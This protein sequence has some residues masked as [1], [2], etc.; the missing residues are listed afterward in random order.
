MSYKIIYGCKKDVNDNFLSLPHKLYKSSNLTQDYKTEYKI[1]N[2]T[3]K[4]SKYF[5]VV[6]FVVMDKTYNKP[7]AR[8][9]LTYYP[10]DNKA[11]FGFFESIDN[12]EVAKLLLTSVYEQ[13]KS[14]KKEKLIGPVDA[15]FWIKYRL[16]INLFSDTPYTGE[17]YNKDYYYKLLMN[18]GFE[19]QNHYTS[20]I[21]PVINKNYN[22]EKFQKHYF[23][24]YYCCNACNNVCF[25]DVGISS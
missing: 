8:C 17:P 11:Y 6:P 16:K 18:N 20:N 9:M 12:N 1:L 22:N 2:K 25:A 14:D 23:T 10:N 5:N 3:H 15:S 24:C 7:V 13:A 19:V 4:L 21:Y